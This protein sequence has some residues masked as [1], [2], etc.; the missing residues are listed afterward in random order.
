[1]FHQGQK[2]PQAAKQALH[3][4]KVGLSSKSVPGEPGQW[5]RL[6][7]NQ[8]PHGREICDGKEPTRS[9]EIPIVVLITETAF[10][11]LPHADRQH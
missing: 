5:R 7:Q 4:R 3:A 10:Q 6:S 2:T 8:I 1:M 9:P 11:C